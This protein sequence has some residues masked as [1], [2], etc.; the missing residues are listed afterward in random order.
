MSEFAILGTFNFIYLILYLV[1][2]EN[3][4]N[5]YKKIYKIGDKKYKNMGG[6]IYGKQWRE[7]IGMYA[8]EPNHVEDPGTLNT[9]NSYLNS[10]IWNL[11]KRSGYVL[12]FLVLINLYG[13]ADFIDSIL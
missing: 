5:P 7:V 1:W 4:N 11:N 12:I 9:L 3:F 13:F 8:L 10:K 2:Q 6:P